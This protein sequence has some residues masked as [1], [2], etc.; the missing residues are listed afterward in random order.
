MR[1][2]CADATGTDRDGTIIQRDTRRVHAQKAPAALQVSLDD[3]GYFLRRLRF[4]TERCDRNG[5]LRQ[6][7]ARDFHTELRKR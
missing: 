1:R 2:P 6:A 7:Y 5:Q 3:G 4:A